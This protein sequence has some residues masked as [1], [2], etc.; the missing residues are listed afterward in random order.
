MKVTVILDV[1]TRLHGLTQLAPVQSTVS[2]VAT[3]ALSEPKVKVRY[4]YC[5]SVSVYD[6]VDEICQQ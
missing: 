6:Y 5:T 1:A 3:R 4:Q 2:V